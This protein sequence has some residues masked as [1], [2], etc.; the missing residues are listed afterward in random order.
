MVPTIM[1]DNHSRI[2][3]AQA[4][5]MGDAESRPAYRLAAVCHR[6]HS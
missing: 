3:D 2:P 6:L 4:P 1:P 5:L